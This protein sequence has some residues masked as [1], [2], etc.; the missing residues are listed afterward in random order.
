MIPHL[1][2]ADD[3]MPVGKKSMMRVYVFSGSPEKS[4]FNIMLVTY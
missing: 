3:M 2:L 4:E 1:I